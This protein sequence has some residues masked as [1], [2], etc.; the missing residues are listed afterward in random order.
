MHDTR[1]RELMAGLERLRTER[2]PT[3][4]DVDEEAEARAAR[5]ADVALVMA[6]SAAKIVA[7]G[8]GGQLEP[9]RRQDFAGRAAALERSLRQLAEQARRRPPGDLEAALAAVES[10]CDSCHGSFREGRLRDGS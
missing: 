3:P 2:L 6:D 1:L 9:S 8:A 5:I 4:M 10:T 7:T